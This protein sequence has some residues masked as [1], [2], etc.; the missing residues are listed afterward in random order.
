MFIPSLHVKSLGSL[1]G[2]TFPN[3]S[4]VAWER[5]N[6]A[7]CSE[8]KAEGGFPT[9]IPFL[10]L[11]ISDPEIKAREYMIRITELTS[12]LRSCIYMNFDDVI[13]Q[14][15]VLGKIFKSSHNL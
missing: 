7:K 15:S 1:T 6:S 2:S 10:T 12:Q 13:F 3:V 4:T 8:P 5:P 11:C 9:F 14:L